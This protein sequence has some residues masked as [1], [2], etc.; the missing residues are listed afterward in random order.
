MHV[1][2]RSHV[3]VYVYVCTNVHMHVCEDQRLMSV[4]FFSYFSPLKIFEITFSIYLV[5]KAKERRSKD[6][7]L[8]LITS[9]QE[10]R[11]RQTGGLLSSLGVHT[12]GI[13]WKHCGSVSSYEPYL[14]GRVY[15]N[16]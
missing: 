4:V 9:P 3:C 2:L 15:A 14:A 6:R 12:L 10:R 11:L 7:I 16:M 13:R 5:R 1:C 8:T